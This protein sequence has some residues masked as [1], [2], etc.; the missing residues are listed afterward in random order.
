MTTTDGTWREVQGRRSFRQTVDGRRSSQRATCNR[1]AGLVDDDDD[2]DGDDGTELEHG[3]AVRRVGQRARGVQNEECG[4]RVGDEAC[5]DVWGA[6]MS[7]VQDEE[8]EVATSQEQPRAATGRRQGCEGGGNKDECQRRHG[9]RRGKAA[10]SGEE[11]QVRSM[12]TAEGATHEHW[13]EEAEG[14][15]VQGA[16]EPTGEMRGQD[17]GGGEEGAN[18]EEC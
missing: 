14:E 6:K 9:Q 18:K 1:F 5:S 4:Q 16:G 7:N 8:A 3:G 11:V 12:G 17:D 13:S 2:G 10:G 15:R